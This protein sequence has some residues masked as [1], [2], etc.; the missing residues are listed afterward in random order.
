MNIPRPRHLMEFALMNFVILEVVDFILLPSLP[1]FLFPILFLFCM[2]MSVTVIN[3]QNHCI[4]EG[5]NT[6]A[7]MEINLPQ[8]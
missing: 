4:L 6:G 2:G 5:G 7:Q 1:V 3:V 8:Y